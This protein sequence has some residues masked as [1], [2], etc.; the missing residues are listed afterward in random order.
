MYILIDAYGIIEDKKGKKEEEARQTL[1]F[2]R[3]KNHR[4]Y[5]YIERKDIQRQCHINFSPLCN[6]GYC[7]QNS[8]CSRL[9]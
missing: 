5:L 1:L 7:E 2:L 6:G 4:E 8:R 3:E 9:L